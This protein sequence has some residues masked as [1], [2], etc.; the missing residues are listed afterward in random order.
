MRKG[1]PSVSTLVQ[2]AAVHTDLFNADCFQISAW[3]KDIKAGTRLAYISVAH[4]RIHY[5]LIPSDA[6]GERIYVAAE[7]EVKGFTK[8]GKR[9]LSFDTNLT[10][11]IQSM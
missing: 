4:M 1:D 10:E 9:F 5:T 2:S 3:I 11:S 6:S 7:T 8:K